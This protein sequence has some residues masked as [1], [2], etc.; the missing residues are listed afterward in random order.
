MRLVRSAL[1][2]AA[3]TALVLTPLPALAQPGA[4]QSGVYLHGEPPTQLRPGHQDATTF[5]VEYEYQAGVGQEE[6]ET[7]INVSVL[8]KPEWIEVTVSPNQFTVP[9]DPGR[10]RS[11]QDIRVRVTVERRVVALKPAPITLHVEAKDNGAIRSSN[12]TYGW[13]FEAAFVPEV[14]VGVSRTPLYVGQNEVETLRLHLV[15]KGNAP[16]RPSFRL[17]KSSADLEVGI[18]YS[19]RVLE[20]PLASPH[21]A[22]RVDLPVLVKPLTSDWGNEI[23]AVEI[24]YR[25]TARPTGPVWTDSI[26]FLVLEP[27]IGFL[28]QVV[29]P[30][31]IVGG[32]AGGT[33]AWHRRRERVQLP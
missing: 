15:N 24:D 13:H 5:T 9:V 2:I 23:V 7:Q 29:L 32:I 26:Q 3:V 12:N 14:E 4:V 17:S 27:A 33:W 8:R 11:T 21:D 20:T 18:G 19:G 22:T 31:A 30:M 1:A 16:I 25:P 10:T 6:S 28:G